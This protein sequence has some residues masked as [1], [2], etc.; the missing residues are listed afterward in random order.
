MTLQSRIEKLEQ[1]AVRGALT[2]CSHGYDIRRYSNDGE[3]YAMDDEP[4]QA[5]RTPNKIC[6]VC[7]GEQQRFNLI[8]IKG[9]AATAA[10]SNQN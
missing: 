4:E 7:G 5:D 2:A 9:R 10:D 3:G 1:S 8:S 6:D